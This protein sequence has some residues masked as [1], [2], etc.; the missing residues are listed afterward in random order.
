[1]RLHRN[2]LLRLMLNTL[3]IK[4]SFVFLLIKTP[5]RDLGENNISELPPRLLH[6][7]IHLKQ[8]FF[9][10]N[11]IKTVPS[12]FFNGLSSLEWLMLQENELYEFPLQELEPL[13]S[14]EW[15]DL[16]G[17][18]LQF[19]GDRFPEQLVHMREM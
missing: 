6:S 3:F 7:Q 8:L 4:F 5:N 2:I 13:V 9:R 1:M 17:N 15:L 12:G 19:D 10:R 11:H 18:L 16:S 14:L